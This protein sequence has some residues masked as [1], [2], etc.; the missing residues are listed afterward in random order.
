[1]KYATHLRSLQALEL[2][3]RKGSI[4]AAAEELAITPAA[5]GQRIKVLEHY[6]G[7]ELVQRGRHGI[8]PA[9]EMS[10]ALAHL[11]AAFREL[12]TV[13]RLL[14]FQR[15]IEIHITADSDWAQLWLA[16]RLARYKKENSNTLFCVN[17]IGDVPMRI[18]DADCEVGFNLSGSKSDTEVLFHDLLLPVTSPANSERVAALPVEEMLEGFPLL[19]IDSYVLDA[20]EMG[21]PEWTRRFGHRRSSPERG[22]RYQRVVQALEAVYAD[23]GFILCGASL[24]L[25]QLEKGMLSAPFPV[26]ERVW[27]DHPYQV[28]FK[29][30]ASPGG[31]LHHFRNW[32][33]SEAKNS[34]RD[35]ENIAVRK[36]PAV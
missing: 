3:I 10:P 19:H 5:V 33:L 16:P 23:A 28:R 35:L 2:A 22:I 30:D 29:A 12:G 1:M 31:A 17:G 9:P 36:T 21:W 34:Q 24:V 26:D 32:L 7:Y 11:N 27:T 14:D 25:P 20:E 15:A 13:F 8:R 18:G 4:K 6:L